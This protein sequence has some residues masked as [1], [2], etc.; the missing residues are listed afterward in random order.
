LSSKELGGGSI[1][2]PDPWVGHGQTH[3]GVIFS[4]ASPAP[5]PFFSVFR[6][7]GFTFYVY[8]LVLNLKTSFEALET[9]FKALESGFQAGQNGFRQVK[10]VSGDL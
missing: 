2:N 1:K 7:K 4:D 8:V 5:E 6:M 3:R 9:G 10:M